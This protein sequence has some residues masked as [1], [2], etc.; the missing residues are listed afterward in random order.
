MKFELA[1]LVLAQLVLLYGQQRE[2][3]IKK[4]G[5]LNLKKLSK[6][7]NDAVLHGYAES[8]EFCQQNFKYEPWNCPKPQAVKNAKHPISFTDIYEHATKE[9]SYIY[10]I[11]AAGVTHYVIRACQQGKDRNCQCK[12]K[13][14]KNG[15]GAPVVMC[16]SIIDHGTKRARRIL[17]QMDFKK[18]SDPVRK[19]FNWKNAASGLQVY[20]Q[21]MPRECRCSGVSGHCT[22]TVCWEATPPSLKVPAQQLKQLYNK[23]VKIK[24]TEIEKPFFPTKN[25][26]RSRPARNLVNDTKLIYITDS[27]SYCKPNPLLGLPGTLNR[28]CDH[29]QDNS[30]NKLCSKCGYRKHSVVKKHINTKCNCKFHWCCKVTCDTCIERRLVTKCYLPSS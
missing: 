28:E 8:Y 17:K 29:T 11:V 7:E 21:L 1:F 6:L 25:P 15:L 9:A 20:R 2:K 16:Q 18:V 26:N 19:A 14:P 22:A 10:S 12:S 24:P 13:K 5:G 4:K 27:P 30:C 3:K 23:A